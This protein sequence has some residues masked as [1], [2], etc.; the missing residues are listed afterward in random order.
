MKR[1]N[2]ACCYFPTTVLFLDDKEEF[3]KSLSLSLDKNLVY[4]TFS[5]P[6][7][8]KD[9]LYQERGFNFQKH[10]WLFNLHEKNE[11]NYRHAH[12]FINFDISKIYKEIYSLNKF[13]EI[14]VIVVDY[15]A[16][17]MHGLEFSRWIKRID[18]NLIKI[19]MLTDEAD[20][21]LAIAAFNE[22]IIDRF[23]KKNAPMFE[24]E[25]NNAINSLQF[26]YFCDLTKNLTDSLS[27]S[28]DCALND[29]VFIDFFKELIWKHN[30]VEYYLID[31]YGSFLLLDIS[32]KPS[33]LVIKSNNIVKQY[34][35]IA[36][37]NFAPEAIKEVLAKFE[38]NPF[39]F[40]QEST[41]MPVTKWGDYLH[42][43]H[44]LIGK[45]NEYYIAFIEDTDNYD[46]NSKEII[47]YQKYLDALS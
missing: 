37:D 47:S 3:L 9:F 28:E 10:R 18:N 4:R 44:K 43:A 16:P 40:T 34:Y 23:I 38:K 8:A 21:E 33:W 36:E 6:E 24:F 31:E 15:M 30:F 25:L 12:S 32:G 17:C 39:F 27:L 41:E 20:E 35:H 45:K 29:P 22:G 7:V 26:K 1:N 19:F 13:R 11:L 5:N 2:M 42:P 46:I 14:S